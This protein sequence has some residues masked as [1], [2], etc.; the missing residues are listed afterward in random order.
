MSTVR[1]TA[2]MTGFGVAVGV[3][4]AGVGVAGVGMA[5]VGMAGVGVGGVG[6][7]TIALG[8]LITRLGV[9]SKTVVGDITVI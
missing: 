9:G 4:T 6:V 7:E 1:T 3:G 8:V 2:T 5:G